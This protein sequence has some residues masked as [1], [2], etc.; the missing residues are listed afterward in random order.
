MK[1][2]HIYKHNVFEYILEID[3]NKSITKYTL[4]FSSAPHWT[5]PFETAL[6]IIDTG[7]GY[8]LKGEIGKEFNYAQAEYFL[9]LLYIIE[10]I[11]RSTDFIEYS[12]VSKDEKFKIEI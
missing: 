11:E 1:T 8:K 5:K 12:I 3:Q 6:C 10:Y 2:Y 9:I 7:S 4:K